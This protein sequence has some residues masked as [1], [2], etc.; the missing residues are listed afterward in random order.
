M[1]GNFANV[2]TPDQVKDTCDMIID[3]FIFFLS[4]MFVWPLFSYIFCLGAKSPVVGFFLGG[5]GVKR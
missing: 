2:T 3:I 5:G 4:C 1:V